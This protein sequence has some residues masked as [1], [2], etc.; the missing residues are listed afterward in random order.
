MTT[1]E[2]AFST[3]DNRESATYV[4]IDQPINGVVIDA[5]GRV[6]PELNQQASLQR[7]PYKMET[8]DTVS[9]VMYDSDAN[10]AVPIIRITEA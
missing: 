1:Q 4:A 8:G 3:W 5:F 10:G 2:W 9:Y 7:R 6:R